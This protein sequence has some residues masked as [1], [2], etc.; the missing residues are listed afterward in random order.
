[1]LQY[2]GFKQV[3]LGGSADDAAIDAEIEAMQRHNVNIFGWFVD[4]TDNPIVGVDWKAH[5]IDTSDH[6]TFP[7]GALLEAFKR[8]GIAPQLWLARNMR[9]APTALPSTKP[10]SEMTAE[11]KNQDFRK[12]LNYDPTPAHQRAVRIRREVAHLMPLMQLAASYGVRV[13]LYKHGGWLG[14]E[15]NAVAVIDGLRAGGANNVGL[16]YR[17]IHVHD[18]VDDTVD[19]PV[20]WN[21]IRPYVWVVDITGVHAG[22]TTVYP[23]LYPSQGDLELDMMRI[24]QHSGWR[25]IIGVSAE[26]AAEI[27]GDASGHLQNNL[28]GLD[29]LAAKLAQAS[30]RRPRPLG[31]GP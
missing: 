20:M 28:I 31:Y 23:I 21:K 9:L 14:I 29:W 19:F 1:M 26:K 6:G 3:T 18:E 25:G 30:C 10:F 17:F 4:D 12:Y 27:G 13:A 7:L 15:D 8:H 24:I 11:E 22:R 16:V 5:T 2:L